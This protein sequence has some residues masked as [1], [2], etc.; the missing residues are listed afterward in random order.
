LFVECF[1][2]S[3]VSETKICLMSSSESATGSAAQKHAYVTMVTSDSFITGADVMI[4]SLLETGT[5]LEIIVLVTPQVSKAQRKILEKRGAKVREVE[6]LENPSEDCH[7]EGW[8]NSGRP[9]SLQSFR[10]HFLRSMYFQ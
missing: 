7:V 3:D 8:V 1:V 9:S 10:A 2:A 5:K 6:P 4:F